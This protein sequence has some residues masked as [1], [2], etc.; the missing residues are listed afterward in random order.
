[1]FI[2]DSK[3]SD[4]SDKFNMSNITFNTNYTR[5]YLTLDDLIDKKVKN[6]SR[7]S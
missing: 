4:I 3:M 2:L 6:H 1:M 5:H 7:T